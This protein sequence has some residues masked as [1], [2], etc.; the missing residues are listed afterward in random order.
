MARK[1]RTIATATTAVAPQTDTKP[2]ERYQDNFQQNFGRKAEEFGKTIESQKRNLLY[3]LGAL[4]VLAAL[5]GTYFLWSSR[6]NAAAQSALGKAIETSEA[7]LVNT[8]PAAGSTGKQFRTA[9]ERA[10]AAIPEFQAV[11]DQYGGNVAEKA[12]YF[13]AVNQLSL[14]RPT[15]VQQLEELSKSGGEVGTLSKFALAQTRADDGRVDEAIALYK[16]LASASDNVVPK[17]TVNVELA[18]IYEKQGKKQEAVD[19]LFSVVK[20]ASEAKDM[21]GKAIPL[22]ASAQAA[23][24]K[25]AQLDPEKAKEIPEPATDTPD[26]GQSGAQ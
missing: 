16:E 14:D 1:K 20:S 7:P 11:V 4:V 8:A 18:R 13:I 25:L 10:Q 24:D 21:D 19:L 9:K 26:L 22:S 5:I 17:D 23:K 12:K 2:K 6:T 15:G 3:G